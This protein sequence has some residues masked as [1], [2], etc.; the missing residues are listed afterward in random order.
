VELEARA[1]RQFAQIVRLGVDAA[2][3]S[4]RFGPLDDRL[5]TVGA[6]AVLDTRS[7]PAFPRNAVLLGGGWSELNLRGMATINRYEADARGYVGVVGQSVAAGRVQYFS[8]DAGLPPYERLLLGGSSTLRGFRAGTFDGDRMLVTSAELR[9]P[10]TAVISGA[11][12]GITVFVDAAKA[13]DFGTRLEDGAWHRG[14]GAGLFLIAPLVKIN[15]DV[16]HGLNGGGTR[17]NIGSGFSF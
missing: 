7:D 8:T 3:S 2:R 14:A 16:A 1:E 17:L 5:W 9:A 4:V 6:N 11:K 10:I 13:V 15:L 12:L